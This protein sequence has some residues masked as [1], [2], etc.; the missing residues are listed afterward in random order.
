MKKRFTEFVLDGQAFAK[1]HS[2][3]EYAA[4]MGCVVCVREARSA[5]SEFTTANFK[6]RT[7]HSSPVSAKSR[8]SDDLL[9]RRIYDHKRP[10][11]SPRLFEEERR[12][13]AKT[14][15]GSVAQAVMTNSKRPVLVVREQPQ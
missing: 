3:N 14:L 13:L 5:A 8:R 11:R 6:S 10:H 7:M 4:R 2:S 15:L 1:A 12:G 9:I